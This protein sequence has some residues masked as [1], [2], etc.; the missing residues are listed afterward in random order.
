MC[1]NMCYQEK[2]LH[3]QGLK[4]VWPCRQIPVY[5]LQNFYMFD[6]NRNGGITMSQI[7]FEQYI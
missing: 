1:P 2:N 3:H 4:L 7:S 5:L 6:W